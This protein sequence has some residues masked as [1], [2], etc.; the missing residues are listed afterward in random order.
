VLG[1]PELE[2]FFVPIQI[3]DV[4]VV[5]F[6]PIRAFRDFC[7]FTGTPNAHNTIFLSS[8]STNEKRAQHVFSPA[9]LA[10][11]ALNAAQ[12]FESFLSWHG[13]SKNSS[14]VSLVPKPTQWPQNSLAA[15][16]DMFAQ[17]GFLIR[18][19][20]AESDS[21]AWQLEDNSIVFGTT[22]Q[23]LLVK[24]KGACK[25]LAIIDTGGTKGRTIAMSLAET[26]K[27][28]YERYNKPDTFL[29]LSE[30]GMCELGSQAWSAAPCHDGSFY[31]AKTLFPFALDLNLR[32]AL[33]TGQKGF[34]AFIDL[35]NLQ[36]SYPAIITEDLGCLLDAEKHLF[37][38]HHR[39]PHATLK[40]CSLNVKENFNFHV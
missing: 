16:I 6:L 25:R 1:Q 36:E 38:F 5:D 28:F 8:G 12:H 11:Y 29:F 26:Q 40:G 4:G 34:L 32:M 27:I 7:V 3:T 17:Q 13:F 23:H 19:V 21:Y 14:I 20:D 35:I 22:F 37:Q 2:P 30:Y 9:R 39:A 10:Q 31:A 18:Y 33:P 24:C 15:M